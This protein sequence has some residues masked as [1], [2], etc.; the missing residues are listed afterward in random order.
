MALISSQHELDRLAQARQD[1]NNSSPVGYQMGMS[2][3]TTEEQDVKACLQRSH[4]LLNACT[5][6]F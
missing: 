6:T 2:N 1:H 5:V 4:L 3:G